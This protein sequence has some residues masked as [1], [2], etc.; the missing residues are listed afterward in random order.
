MNEN[1][2]QLVEKLKNKMIEMAK[3]HEK[4]LARKR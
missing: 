2:V 3:H 4:E 1:N